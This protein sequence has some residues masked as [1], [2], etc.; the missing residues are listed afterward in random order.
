MKVVAEVGQRVGLH[1]LAV[2][3]FILPVFCVFNA[4]LCWKWIEN[5][6][7]VQAQRWAKKLSQGARPKGALPAET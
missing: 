7:T 2:L 3:V 6:L 1:S 4:W 5:P